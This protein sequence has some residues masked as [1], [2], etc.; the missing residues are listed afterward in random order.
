MAQRLQL[1]VPVCAG[2]ERFCAPPGGGGP[3]ISAG[4]CESRTGSGNLRGWSKFQN[5]D[6]GDWNFRK[7]TRFDL[8][9]TPA[10]NTTKSLYTN[11]GCTAFCQTGHVELQADNFST[12]NV[13]TNAKDVIARQHHI[14]CQT[15]FN[16]DPEVTL[17]G[18]AFP[19]MQNV[20]PVP[21]ISTADFESVWGGNI[22]SISCQFDSPSGCST[23][24]GV[25]PTRFSADGHHVAGSYTYTVWDSV[26]AA[27]ARGTSSAGSLCRTTAGT[28]GSTT[29]AST[30]QIA[31]S[32]T[33]S[34]KFP[35]TAANLAPNS[36]YEFDIVLNRYTAG[37]GGFVDEIVETISITTGPAETGAT[38]YYHVPVNTDYD[39]EFDRVENL[40]LIP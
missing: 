35:W 3:S 30:T 31:I 9:Q 16:K 1:R 14:I 7:A 21:T 20:F 34:S 28:I 6:A 10:I 11:S 27:L 24:C 39:Y 17:L 36:T 26:D 15:G 23:A 4:P 19:A 40:V 2:F 13:A 32:G 18:G 5:Q 38:D 12:W 22:A 37:G 33:T 25:N 8:S 29:A